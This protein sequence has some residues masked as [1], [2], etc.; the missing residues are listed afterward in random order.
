MVFGRLADI[1]GR[2]KVF[3]LGNAFLGAIT[4]GCA[5]PTS[6]IV[7]YFLSYV[8]ILRLVLEVLTLEV[9]RGIQGI[10]SA[11]VIP[12]SASQPRLIVLIPLISFTVRHSR[13]DFP[14][15]SRPFDGV[16]YVFSWCTHWF[17]IWYRDRRS[18]YTVHGVCYLCPAEGNRLLTFALESPGGRIST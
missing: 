9:L 1:Y 16:C 2:K 6:K 8:A 15:V 5:F 7:Y 3:L 17:S 13:K 10:G 4:L 18:P 14:S 12:A 11:A